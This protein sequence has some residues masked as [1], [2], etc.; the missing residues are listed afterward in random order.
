MDNER[1]ELLRVY[2]RAL[3]SIRPKLGYGDGLRLVVSSDMMVTLMSDPDARQDFNL[4]M[5]PYSEEWQGIPVNVDR[6][7]DRDD[8]SEFEFSK[9]WT[10][11][12]QVKWDNMRFRPVLPTD[13]EAAD[14]GED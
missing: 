14:N 2:L 1:K 3:K 7:L 4:T 13:K 8:N 11:S 6:R 9:I 12:N 10:H 5:K